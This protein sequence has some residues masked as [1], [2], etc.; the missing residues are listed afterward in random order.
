MA[1]GC[2]GI[3]AR[4]GPVSRPAS[5]ASGGGAPPT[6]GLAFPGLDLE[7]AP[8]VA[9]AGDLEALSAALARF[10]EITLQLGPRLAGVAWEQRVAALVTTLSPTTRVV[11]RSRGALSGLLEP[12]PALQRPRR[13]LGPEGRPRYSAVSLRSTWPTGQVTALLS[14]DDATVDPG[15]WQAMPAVSVGTCEP[16]MQALALGQEQALVQL[17]PFLDQ[18]DAA[19]AASHRAQ[20][21]RHLTAIAAGLDAAAG[22]GSASE[23]AARE[24][25]VRGYRAELTAY[26]GCMTAASCPGS[27]RVVLA[28]GVQVIAP[29]VPA[30]ATPVAGSCAALVGR[31]PSAEL[32][33]LAQTAT[34][35]VTA[36]LDP[37]WVMLADRLG[38]LSEVHAAL[39]DICTPRRR[40]FAGPDLAEARRRLA[41][42]GVALASEDHGGEGLWQVG[43]PPVGAPAGGASLA[44]FEAGPGSINA[45]IVAEARALRDFVIGRSMCRSGHAAAPVAVLLAAPGPGAGE[46]AYF[47]YFHEEELFCGD[48]PPLGFGPSASD[49]PGIESAPREHALDRQAGPRSQHN[50]QN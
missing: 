38:K 5:V 13:T 39:E 22:S 7:W 1:P 12:G 24:P 40:R 9:T 36:T 46:L 29:D 35:S 21:E 10:P 23:V 3:R 42:I 14:L 16:A 33:V 20:L 47:G 50:A 25:C 11:M 18:A 44:R 49:P 31:D 27:P 4:V 8:P 48:L 37:A 30:V 2:E 34:R 32:R 15:V 28:G 45:G 19:L 17:A 41:R 26:A 43:E 6:E